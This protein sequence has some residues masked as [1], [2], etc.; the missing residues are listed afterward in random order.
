VRRDDEGLN[1]QMRSI[2]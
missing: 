2:C 1:P